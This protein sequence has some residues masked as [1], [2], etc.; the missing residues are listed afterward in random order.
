MEI[1]ESLNG[2]FIQICA[3]KKKERKEKKTR[4]RKRK[5]TP[6]YPRSN[7]NLFSVNDLSFHRLQPRC[8]DLS[9]LSCPH[10]SRANKVQRIVNTKIHA[11]I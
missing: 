1:N 3:P 4:K 2:L 7:D 11:V 10:E 9:L 8:L 5:R 6:S